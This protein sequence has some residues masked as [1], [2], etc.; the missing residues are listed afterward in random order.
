M[1]AFLRRFFR[2]PV[3]FRF[4]T[5]DAMYQKDP[6]LY[7]KIKFLTVPAAL[8]AWRGKYPDDFVNFSDQLERWKTQ[9]RP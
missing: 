9:Q 2:K 1:L 5:N 7:D 6:A 8:V 3:R 4:T